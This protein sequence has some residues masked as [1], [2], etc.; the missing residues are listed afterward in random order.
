[1]VAVTL[2]DIERDLPGYLSRVEAGETVVILRD[3]RPIAEIRPVAGEPRQPRPHGLA[4]GEFATPDDFDA[5]L[6][7]DILA[8]FEGR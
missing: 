5:P 1:M 4:A 8:V 6:P 2:N 3:G 7:D